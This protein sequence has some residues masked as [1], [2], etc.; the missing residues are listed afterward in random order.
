MGEGIPGI[1]V[2]LSLERQFFIFFA[3]SIRFW[4]N[5]NEVKLYSNGMADMV[6]FCKEVAT[7]AQEEEINEVSINSKIQIK[8]TSVQ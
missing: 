7:L 2:C 6:I 1:I 8:T 3:R 4:I 5:S